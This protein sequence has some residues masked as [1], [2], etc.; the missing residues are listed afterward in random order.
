[1]WEYGAAIEIFP[2]R[3]AAENRRVTLMSPMPNQNKK[4]QAA[5]PGHKKMLLPP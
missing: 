5:K 4:L 2:N 1:M 3:I